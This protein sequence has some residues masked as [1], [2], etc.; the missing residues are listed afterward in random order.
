MTLF[1][2]ENQKSLELKHMINKSPK[3]A[4]LVEKSRRSLIVQ[5]CVFIFEL[6]PKNLNNF[7]FFL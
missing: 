1:L 2:F 7:M 4:S 3:T 5:I 6:S